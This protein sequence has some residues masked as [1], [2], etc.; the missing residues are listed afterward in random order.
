LPRKNKQPES[1]SG[2]NVVLAAKTQA[3][4][5]AIKAIKDHPITIISGPPGT[6]KTHIPVIFGLQQLLKGK[7][8]RLIFTRPCVEAYGERLGFMPGDYN[9]K[10]LP[11]MRPIMEILEDAIGRQQL[12]LLVEEGMVQTIPLAFQRGVTFNNAFVV[13]DEFQNT[14]P[15]QVR[16]FLTRM[17]ENC[18]IVMTGDPSQY[19]DVSN[20]GLVDSLERFEDV[21]EIA[22]IKMLHSDIVRNPLIEKIDRKYID[23]PLPRREG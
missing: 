9:Q 22:I 1:N 20:N 3:Q 11:Y 17:G 23:N 18:K 12:A 5:D 14:I 4:I 13:G 21:E 2:P 7:Y 15:E 19:D 10:I 16:M 6:G 8:K